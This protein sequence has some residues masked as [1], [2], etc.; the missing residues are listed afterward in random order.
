MELSVEFNRRISGFLFGFF[1]CIF[2][3]IFVHGLDGIID[4]ARFTYLFFKLFSKLNF[5]L[6]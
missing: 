3:Y 1:L 5:V 2:F 4:V 6:K